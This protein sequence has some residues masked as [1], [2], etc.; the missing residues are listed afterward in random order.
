MA[1]HWRVYRAEV[2]NNTIVNCSSG[3]QI[4]PYEKNIFSAV[5]CKIANNIIVGPANKLLYEA[6]VPEKTIYEGNIVW[7]DEPDKINIG[8][9]ANEFKV[10]NPQLINDG[11]YRLDKTSPAIDAAVGAYSYVTEDIDGQKRNKNDIGADE[12]STEAK[13]N[14]PLKPEN[15]GINS[16]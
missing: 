6:Q 2:T 8:K 1:K 4:T 9:A 15:V 5:G 16:K 14:L 12:F 13:V 10:I 7:S 11:I 3:I